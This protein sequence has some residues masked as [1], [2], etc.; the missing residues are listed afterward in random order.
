M[1]LS[2]PEHHTYTQNKKDTSNKLRLTFTIL[3]IEINSESFQKSGH[4]LMAGKY[5]LNATSA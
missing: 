5:T 3:K 1:T 4:N 2:I